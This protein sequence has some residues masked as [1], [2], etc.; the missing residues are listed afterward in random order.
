MRVLGIE[1]GKVREIRRIALNGEFAE[2]FQLAYDQKRFI[3]VP[4]QFTV[5]L[6]N[7]SVVLDGVI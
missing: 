6:E 7:D 4:K 5:R 2:P 3:G 1:A